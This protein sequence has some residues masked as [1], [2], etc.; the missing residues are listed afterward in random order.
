MDERALVRLANQ[1]RTV[2]DID[3]LHLWAKDVVSAV[4]GT[5]QEEK[6]HGHKDLRLSDFGYWHCAHCGSTGD[7]FDAPEDFPCTPTR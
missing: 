3:T 4:E 5:S 2:M 7:D 1:Y 6:E